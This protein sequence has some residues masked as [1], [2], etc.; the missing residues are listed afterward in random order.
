MEHSE[1]NQKSLLTW[2]YVTRDGKTEFCNIR[3]FGLQKNDL[4]VDFKNTSRPHLVSQVLLGCLKESN[5]KTPSVDQIWE[6]NLKQRLQALIVVVTATIGKVLQAQVRCQEPICNE[7]FELLLDLTA[8]KNTA[9]NDDGEVMSCLIDNTMIKMRL[10]TGY[11]QLKWLEQDGGTPLTQ[12]AAQLVVS[13]NGEEPESSFQLPS[14]W[15][16]ELGAL[17]DRNDKLMSLNVETSCPPC[18]T[19]LKVAMDLE[20]ELLDSLAGVQRK[21]Y[22]QVHELASHYHW[23]EEDVMS[24]SP[25]RRLFYLSQ[26]E[27]GGR[28]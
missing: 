2:S 24:L 1:L 7:L 15:L 21:L 3:A 8:L 20:K 13:I 5:L 28:L 22:I 12:M 23:T 11:D 4:D 10:P 16:D 25:Q 9:D 27:E 6:L 26:F 17:L 18:G 19:G 14:S